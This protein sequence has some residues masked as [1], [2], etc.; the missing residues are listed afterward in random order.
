M[1]QGSN[2]FIYLFIYLLILGNI[3]NL[4]LGITHSKHK[5]TVPRPE[6]YSKV[7]RLKKDYQLA[8]TSAWKGKFKKLS[9]YVMELINK[10]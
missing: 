6:F 5:F 9:L 8:S 7:N 10:A 2:D 3:T 1:N 4:S